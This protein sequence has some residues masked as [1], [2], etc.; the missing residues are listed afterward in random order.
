MNKIKK[1]NN[2]SRSLFYGSP[3]SFSVN[4]NKTVTISCLLREISLVKSFAYAPE[5]WNHFE[6]VINFS[7]DCL[8]TFYQIFVFT[9]LSTS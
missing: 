1:G 5:K 7:I 6:I 3:Y 2:Q 4:E 9:E 8:L